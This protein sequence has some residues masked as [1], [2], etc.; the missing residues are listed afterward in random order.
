[1]ITK[2]TLYFNK[3]DD[4]LFTEVAKEIENGFTVDEIF[5]S[6]TLCINSVQPDDF[7]TVK[8]TNLGGKFGF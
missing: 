7:I 2:K 8:M 1:M 6:P 3:I 4:T 5:T